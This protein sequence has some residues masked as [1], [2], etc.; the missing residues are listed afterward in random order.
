VL[1]A[2]IADETLTWTISLDTLVLLHA[3]R[4]DLTDSPCIHRLLTSTA[5]LNALVFEAVPIVII[6]HFRDTSVSSAFMP[7]A[8]S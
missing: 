8:V 6:F 5:R 2:E 7:E 3:E 1:F 4:R